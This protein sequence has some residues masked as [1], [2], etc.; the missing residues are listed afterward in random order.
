M[1]MDRKLLASVVAFLG[2]AV[3]LVSAFAEPLGLG[4]EGGTFGWKQ[5]LGVVIGALVF[6]GG[7][8]LRRVGPSAASGTADVPPR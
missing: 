8:I 2:I 3:A 1:V 6:V 4:S 7:M 5:I